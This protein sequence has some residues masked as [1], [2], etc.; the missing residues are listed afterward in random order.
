MTIYE[1]NLLANDYQ[2]Q[3]LG[4][5]NDMAFAVAYGVS[6]AFGKGKFKPLKENKQQTIDPQKKKEVLQDIISNLGG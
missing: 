2:T 6:S 4:Q 1:S 5:L 3:R